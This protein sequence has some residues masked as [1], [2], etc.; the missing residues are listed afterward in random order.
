MQN[1]AHINKHKFVF[2]HP[3]VEGSVFVA[4]YLYGLS[5]NPRLAPGGQDKNPRLVLGWH[6]NFP[7]LAFGWQENFP[8]LELGHLRNVV[9]QDRQENF[10]KTKTG[11]SGNHSH[12]ACLHCQ[13][14]SSCSRTG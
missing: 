9:P 4:T 1:E 11:R 13:V 10:E 5:K 14:Q 3:S 7:K 8:R 12:V 2:P 6:E